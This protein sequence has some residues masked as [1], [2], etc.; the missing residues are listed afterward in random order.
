MFGRVFYLNLT[1][2][3]RE[4]VIKEGWDTEIGKAYLDAREKGDR[5]EALKLGMF[6]FAA[7]VKGGDPEKVWMALQFGTPGER[8]QE[9][10]I[11]TMA[12][13]IR[14][15]DVGDYILWENGV[16]EVC[17]PIGFEID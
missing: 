4:A 6:R 8:Y 11:C 9:E 7:T 3:Q 16:L 10:V 1:D 5:T 12:G 14:S 2:R 13:Q 15:M 17:K